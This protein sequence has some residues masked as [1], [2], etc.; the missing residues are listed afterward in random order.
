MFKNE[1]Y[2]IKAVNDIIEWIINTQCITWV[3]VGYHFPSTV[4]KNVLKIE[5]YECLKGTHYFLVM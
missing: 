2:F 5:K 4:V 1:S 3:I